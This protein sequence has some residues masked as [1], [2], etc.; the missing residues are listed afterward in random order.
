VQQVVIPKPGEVSVTE[1]EPRRPAPDEAALRV[2]AIGICGSD[3][4]TFN[5]EHPFVSY[6]V[7]PGHELV[8]M[9]EA[10][11]E[12]V[13]LALVGTRVALEPSLPCGRCRP[14]CEGRYNICENLE[15]LGFQAPGGMA[16]RF[17]V[18][19]D[20]LHPL[21]DSLELDTAAL[22][23]PMAVA[24]HAARL[25][26]ALAAS[27][28]GVV[29]GGTIGLLT[30]AAALAYGAARVVVADPLPERRAVAEA[31]GLTAVD[32][33]EPGSCDVVFE[34]VGSEGALR[35]GIDA[36][37]K[38]ATVIV[39]GVFG[40][41]ARVQAGLVQDRE[42]RLQGSLMYVSSDVR[43]A[44]RLLAEGRVAASR[45]VTHRF[46]LAEAERAFAVAAARGGALKVLLV[47]DPVPAA[48]EP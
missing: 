36:C 2:E 12:G 18:R 8:G 40:A 26:G 35:A 29:G 22:V 37:M 27:S 5:G 28:V 20:R 21:P 43:D 47:P 44:I 24:V 46:R 10:V 32:A 45:L 25:P 38:G 39:A 33:L 7:W 1:A 6:P 9:V 13:D 31:L 15:V 4:H 17:T 42:L 19:A 34:C 16:E 11:G 14:C 41:D 48:A 30:G 3:I 23:E